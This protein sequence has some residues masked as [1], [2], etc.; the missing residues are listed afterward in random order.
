MRLTCPECAAQYEI[1]DGLIPP[2][3]RDVECSACGHGWHEPG[4]PKLVL[5]ADAAVDDDL[6]DPD[7]LPPP[8]ASGLSDPVLA[9]LREEAE[10][11]LSARAE[12]RGARRGALAAGIAEATRRPGAEEGAALPDPHALAASLRWEVPARP[13]ELALPQPEAPAMPAAL[14]EPARAAAIVA[15]GQQRAHDRGFAVALL[16][17]A[18][19]AGAYAAAPSLAARGVASAP[20]MQAR[21]SVD[22]GRLWLQSRAEALTDGAIARMRALRD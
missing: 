22:E 13:A 2:E 6:P 1:A 7:D 16:A 14:P 21:A 5:T 8:A 3:G 18:L 17:A 19:L 20:L 15:A 4:A 10:R 12:E 9:I 11:E